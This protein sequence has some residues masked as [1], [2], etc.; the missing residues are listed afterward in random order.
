[1]GLLEVF[2]EIVPN[3]KTKTKSMKPTFLGK[4]TFE[5]YSCKDS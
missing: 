3:L 5:F 2:L 1:M 4:D